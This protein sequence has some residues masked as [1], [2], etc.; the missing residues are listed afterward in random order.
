MSTLGV[1]MKGITMKKSNK[2][3]DSPEKVRAALAQS[4]PT[5]SAL[6][7]AI[8]KSIKKNKEALKI[9]AKR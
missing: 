3:Q 8:Q 9:L 4:R 7:S 5:K 1:T 2:T 6:K